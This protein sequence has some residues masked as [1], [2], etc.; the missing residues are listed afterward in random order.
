[1][2]CLNGHRITQ[3]SLQEMEW[4]HILPLKQSKAI[5]TFVVECHM[6]IKYT[7]KQD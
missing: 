6:S 2:R 4:Q 3:K 7:S 5:I 1:M